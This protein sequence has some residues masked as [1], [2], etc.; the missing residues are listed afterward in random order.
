MKVEEVS[1]LC[2]SVRNSKPMDK[3]LLSR[4]IAAVAAREVELS[5]AESWLKAVHMYGISPQDTITLTN[6][7]MNSGSILTWEEQPHLVVD[8]HSTGGVGDKMSL[9]LAPALA[10]CGLKV[11]MLAGRGLGHTGGTIDKLESI[12]GFNCN[13]TPQQMQD[14][15]QKIGCCIAAQNDAIAPA[16][17]LLYAIRD[18]TQTI[19]SI[20]LI[21]ASI[22]S[23]K[24]AEGLH[25]LV[26][27]V[28]CGTAAFMKTEHDAIELAKSM[29]DVASGLGIKCQA[30]I[31]LMEN[32]IGSHIGNSLEVIESVEILKGNGHP[33]TKKLVVL[34]GSALLLMSN[35]VQNLNAGEAMI[36]RVL[37]D[38]SALKKFC[39][40]CVHQGVDAEIARRLCKDPLSVLPLSNN[41][42]EIIAQ[43]SGYVHSIDS[44]ALAEI[45]RRHGAGRFS[46]E[47]IIIPDVGYIIKKHIGEKIE[48]GQ[49]WMEFY[50]SQQPKD[51]EI[52]QLSQ[53][54]TISKLIRDNQSRL[55]TVVE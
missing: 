3:I 51:S 11:P 15:V 55:I 52:K 37:N 8:K 38:G 22:I 20:P 39:E 14:I 1:M 36:E 5:A 25:S 46:I 10:A 29:V 47:D 30:Q 45:A 50:F 49:C 13:L 19:D 54:I 34:Q 35:I 16:D 7:M 18:V 4:F 17:G 27:D 42:I 43:H 40:M 53:S 21:T 48:G 31:T 28:K 2:D 26:L 23:K 41:K 6:E 12:P 32:P 44:M 24:A 9:M 33:D